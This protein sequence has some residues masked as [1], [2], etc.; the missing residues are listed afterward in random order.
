MAPLKYVVENLPV[1]S[2]FAVGNRRPVDEGAVQVLAESIKKNGL[3]TPIAVRVD[4]SITDPDTGEVTGGYALITGAHRLG[5]YRLLAFSHIPAIVRDCDEIDAE[6]MEITE[7]LHR[8]DL[9]KEQRDVQV[10]RY[11]ELIAAKESREAAK[12]SQNPTFSQPEVQAIRKGQVG[13][14]RGNKGIVRKVADQTGL[15]KDIVRRALFQ[16]DPVKVEENNARKAQDKAIKQDFSEDAA[17]L[18]YDR[19]GDQD[20]PHLISLLEGA[21]LKEIISGLRRRLHD[22]PVFDRGAA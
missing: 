6:L 22:T 4:E 2:I 12:I 13:Q 11:A 14:G 1:D 16:P 8:A 15:S 20:T 19:L 18:L 9:T 21:S 10:R 3:Q 7:N 17:E 5:A